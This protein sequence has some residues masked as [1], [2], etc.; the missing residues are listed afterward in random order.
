MLKKL[1][2]SLFGTRH[3]REM[4]RVQPIVDAINQEYERLHSV[5]EEELRA[6]DREVARDRRR[7]REA[8]RGQDR[9]APRAR[10]TPRPMRRSGSASIARSPAPTAKEGSRQIFAKRSRSRSTRSC[11][12]RSRRFARER[13]DS[14]GS[15]AMVAGHETPWNM[16]HYDV[17]LIGGIAAAL[18][19]DRGD[20]DG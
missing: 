7:A 20:G 19:Q 3:A 11:R 12:R 6:P 9:G 16:V 4:K 13:A 2:T 18:R 8:A 5:P 14:L 15:T 1:A 10:S 17:Q